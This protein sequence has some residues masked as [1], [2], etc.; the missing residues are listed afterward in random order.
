[1]WKDF[2]QVGTAHPRLFQLSLGFRIALAF[3]QRLRLSEEVTQQQLHTQI[4][5]MPLLPPILLLPVLL[6]SSTAL[7][8]HQRL[9]LSEEVTQ[10]QLHTHRYTYMMPPLPLLLLLLRESWTTTQITQNDDQTNQQHKCC[11][12]E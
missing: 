8:F 11:G 9:R 6:G 5:K 2:V 7:A 4:Y 10:Q 1:M 3:H 12:V